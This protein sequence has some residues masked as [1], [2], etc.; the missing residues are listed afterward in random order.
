[1][2]KVIKN[3]LCSFLREEI[4]NNVDYSFDIAKYDLFLLKHIGD[5]KEITII[6]IGAHNGAFTDLISNHYQL[7]NAILI[8][9]LIDNVNYLRNH[10]TSSNIHIYPCVVSDSENDDATFF[11]NGFSQ[12][13]SL[14]Q[15]KGECD[16]LSGVNVSLKEALIMKTKTLDSILSEHEE[17]NYIDL[18]KIDVQGTEHLVID[19]GRKT[20]LNTKYIWVE[21]SF[22]PLY[23]KSA[24][25]EDIY[26]KLNKMGFILMEI[27]PGHKSTIGEL[28]QADALFFNK[29][30]LN[31]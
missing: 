28:L 16:E 21:V 31:K 23:E 9:P 5:K 11:V 7:K 19:G 24:L 18:V 4:Y 13:S 30:F 26:D 1:M 17:I 6:D 10:F 22:K 2:L 14:L 12:T 3:K 8:E 25:F 15:I 27:S 20:L 29:K